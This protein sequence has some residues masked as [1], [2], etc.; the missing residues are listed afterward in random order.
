MKLT[1]LDSLFVE[2]LKDLYSAAH[3]VL[4]ALP[5]M[6]KLACE[7]RLR[8]A[9]A[10]Q[11]HQAQVHIDRLDRIFVQLG[12]G[13]K[14][15]PCHGIEG[16][17]NSGKELLG[18]E[19]QPTVM[20]AALIAASQRMTYY[21]MAELGTVLALARQLGHKKAAAALQEMQEVSLDASKRL[22]DLMEAVFTEAD[23]VV[24]SV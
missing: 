8:A 2:Q 14:G 21:L 20:D 7:P 24:H 3:Q 5:K 12:V 1:T 13:P 16:I 15:N 6:A 18:D 23:A 4:R 17:I 19:A 11:T 10:D 9:L 22:N